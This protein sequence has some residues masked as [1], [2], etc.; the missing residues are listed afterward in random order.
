MWTLPRVG[1]YRERLRWVGEVQMM[2]FSGAF[3]AVAGAFSTN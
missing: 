2:S 3:A 1:F